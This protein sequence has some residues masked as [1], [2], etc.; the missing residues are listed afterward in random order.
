MEISM[1]N[2][3]F[4]F[5]WLQAHYNTTW[6]CSGI[7]AFVMITY[8]FFFDSFTWLKKAYMHFF[9]QMFDPLEN[10]AR[11]L[12]IIIGGTV[13]FIATQALGPFSLGIALAYGLTW[14]HKSVT[15]VEK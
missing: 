4:F 12:I 5:S 14:K 10:F 6:Q 2:V 13:V 9:T 15:A 1:D 11:I 8:L 3:L 7:I